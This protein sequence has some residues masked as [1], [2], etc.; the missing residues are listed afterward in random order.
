MLEAKEILDIYN[1]RT[2][3]IIHREIVN[4]YA[5]ILCIIYIHM[6]INTYVFMFYKTYK[7]SP[8]EIIMIEGVIDN[9]QGRK[10]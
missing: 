5:Y 8:S 1:C 2:Y 10:V 6:Y 3:I 7:Y 9:L 4:L